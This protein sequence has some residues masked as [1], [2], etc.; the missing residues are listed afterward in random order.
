VRE[1]NTSEILRALNC[2]LSP[3]WD[4]TSARSHAD[5]CS[6]AT[7]EEPIQHVAGPLEFT[8]QGCACSGEG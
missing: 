6:G 5:A 3:G 1:R 7:R 2:S 4:D 8:R